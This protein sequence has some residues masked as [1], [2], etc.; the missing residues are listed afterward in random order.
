[1][2]GIVAKYY[3]AELEGDKHVVSFVTVSSPH[4]GT[5]I[6]HAYPLTVG[7]ELASGSALLKAL[8]EKMPA[9]PHVRALS[10]R[11]PYDVMIF[12]SKNSVISW[13]ENVTVNAL[14]HPMML[15]DRLVR[16][17]IVAFLEGQQVH[18][19]LRAFGRIAL[20][21][22]ALLVLVTALLVWSIS[23][24]TP[25]LDRNWTDDAKT[26]PHITMGT[27]TVV[28]EHIRDWRYEKGKVVSER[29]YDDIFD[30]E[31]IKSASFLIN[32][33][34]KWEG[35]AHTFLIFEF[36][37][38]KKVGI[39]VEARRENGEDYDAFRGL[40]NEYEAWYVFGSPEDLMSRRAIYHDEDLY[41]YPL[42]ISPEAARVVFLELARTAASLETTPIFYN[43][44]TSNCTNL[45]AAAVNRAEPGAIPFHFS[46]V[47]T[48]YSDNQLYDLG[49]IPHDKSFKEIFEEARVD[50]EMRANPPAVPSIN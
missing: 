49:L 39:S 45:L 20:I 7:K 42:A 38:G 28:V 40:F 35:V 21:L 50:E 17:K 34:G 43:T 26:L 23:L 19:L 36:E 3:I 9:L 30:A 46:R 11:T 37:D 10:I 48:G 33:F 24:K 32:P 8:E 44:L 16:R 25:R 4:K 22:G 12:P 47:F 29:Y 1:M 31:E 5:V 6:G 15:T 41:E 27:S 13:G 18:T 14:A 2:G